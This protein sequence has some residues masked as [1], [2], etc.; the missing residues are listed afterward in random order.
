[1]LETKLNGRT[2]MEAPAH[3][4]SMWQTLVHMHRH[5]FRFLTLHCL[6]TACSNKAHAMAAGRKESAEGQPPGS[7]MSFN[8]CLRY[9]CPAQRAACAA[10]A[11]CPTAQEQVDAVARQVQTTL[12]TPRNRRTCDGELEEQWPSLSEAS[13]GTPTGSSA[14]EEASC[15]QL[16]LGTAHCLS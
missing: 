13:P 3:P 2:A 5:L 8:P 9:D 6:Q 14:H 16:P 12:S 11:S 15:L 4:D 10:A 7:S 1:M